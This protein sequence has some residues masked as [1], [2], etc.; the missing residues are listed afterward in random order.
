MPKVAVTDNGFAD[1]APER[2]ILEPL[3]CTIENRQCRTE[4]Q[5]AALVADADYVMTQFAPVSAHAIAAMRKARLIV[6]YGI[7][8]DNVDLAAAARHGIPVFNVPDY[9]IDEVADHTLSLILAL[10]RQV[11]PVT[12][13]VRAGKWAAGRPLEDYRALSDM[14][15]GVIG[16]GRIGRA[17][18]RRLRG[19]QTRI[20]AYDPLLRE[21][22]AQD[23]GCAL[24]TLDQIWAESDLI[25]LHVPATSDTRHLINADS[26]ARMRDR[27]VLINVSRGAIVDTA[28]LVDALQSGKVAGAGL[29]VTDPEPIN[30]D[31]PLL[32][33][34][35]VLITSH[36][37]SVSVRA[38]GTLR[39]RVADTVAR[40]IR[41]EPLPPSV[42]G[43]EALRQV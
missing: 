36:V 22:D 9:C 35:N 43:V 5:V 37:A 12:L 2:A 8:V 42:N 33:M 23:M 25:T 11:V 40:A 26:L 3:G 41:G 21:Q 16:C 17:V 10:T 28:A 24:A 34:E 39:F 20:L 14:T 31:S 4:Q 38:V 15:T 7:G 6:R 1:L 19:F 32:G 27:V 13:S 18:I 30:D 29:D